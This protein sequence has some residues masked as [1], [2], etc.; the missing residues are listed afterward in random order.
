MKDNFRGC[1]LGLAIGVVFSRFAMASVGFFQFN[2]ILLFTEPLLISIESI[3][4]SV[5]VGFLLPIGSFLAYNMI[6]S[7]KKKAETSG[8][9]MA[10]ITNVLV[11][12]KWDF[13]LLILTSLLLV[14]LT[15]VSII[16]Y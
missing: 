6:F 1:L 11:F 8:G 14:A 4:I 16:F 2:F 3:L 12:I 7:T 13:F 15:S 9:K 10:K 5:F